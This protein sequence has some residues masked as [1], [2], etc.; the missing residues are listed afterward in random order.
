MKLMIIDGNSIANRA[1]FGIKALNAPDGTPTNAVF[2]FL[3]IFQRLINEIAPDAVCVSFDKHAPTFRHKACSFY[4]ATRK[5]MPEELKVQMPI[6]KETISAMGISILE[7]DGFEADDILGTVSRICERNKWTCTIV[8]GDK[9][10]LQLVTE[11][12]QVCL[13]KSAMGKTETILY[14]PE[15]FSDEYG[16]EPIKMIDL[17]A[18][19]GDSSDNIPGVKGIGQKTACDLITKYG[20]IN[21]IYSHLNCDEIRASVEKKLAEG[22]KD[23]EISYWLATIFCEIPLEFDPSSCLWD[24]SYQPELYGIFKRLG[25]TKFI[26][27]FGLQ[28]PKAMVSKVLRNDVTDEN[29][30]ETLAAVC[31]SEHIA[32]VASN[33]YDS[34][35][36]YDGNNLFYYERLQCPFGFDRARDT[37]FGSDC[38]KIACNIKDIYRAS[39]LH[40]FETGN[41]VFDVVLAAYLLDA[42]AGNYSLERISETFLSNPEGNAKDV[43]ELYP[44]LNSKLHELDM[45]RLFYEIEMPLCQVLADM[46]QEGVLVD[47]AELYSFGEKLA[48]HIE[49][50]KTEIYSFA[51]HEFNINSPKQLGEVLF[52]ELQLPHGKKTKSGWSTNADI[53]EKLSINYPIVKL[54]LEFRTYS[55]LKSTYTDGLLKVIEPDGRIRTNFQMTVTATGRLSSTEPNL[56][57]IPVRTELGAEIRKMFIPA[58][59]KVLLDADYSQIELRIMAHIA[60]DRTMQKAFLSGED[61]HTVTAG[62]VY[63]VPTEEVTHAMRSSAKAVNFGII[64][65]ISAFSLADDIGV[66]TSEAKQFIDT[67]LNRFKELSVYLKEVV[68]KAKKQGY[69]STLYG[70]RR[71]LPELS[72]SNFNIR[73]FGERVALNMPIQG[74]AADIIKIAMIR[75]SE[76]LKNELPE[77]KLIMQVH[78]ELLL[79]CPAEMAQKAA[80]IIR[81][82]M[83]HVAELAVPLIVDVNIGGSW[84]EVH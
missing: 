52:E 9:D 15:R 71:K 17:K 78:D 35:E 22:R 37:I 16:F 10:S 84:A 36:V 75:V 27:S 57:N 34:F 20:G 55:K 72:N 38:K 1:F 53:L 39:A 79:E 74:T 48:E 42:T 67:Y 50:L 2:G 49:K 62:Y 13:I 4:K 43:Y 59:G 8:T 83:E 63:N 66:S 18:L 68:E 23:A 77:A 7:Q 30:E 19:M 29:L 76:R 69:V 26:A 54:V 58:P 5:P 61:F 32:V 21:E 82:E 70:R 25:F 40:C 11:Y 45:D 65:G 80:E 81:Y 28:E 41:F 44:I 33:N 64:Y 3:S 6:I 46:E 47:R 60:N 56:Q 51:G 31:S 24:K 73:S 12:T 14:T